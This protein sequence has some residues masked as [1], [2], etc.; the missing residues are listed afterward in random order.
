M[1]VT[2]PAGFRAGGVACGI[3]ESGAPDLADV[4]LAAADSYRTIDREALTAEHHAWLEREQAQR[5]API[6][7]QVL[8]GLLAHHVAD[9]RVLR[10]DNGGAGL[11]VDHF[12]GLSHFQR[13]VH[14]KRRP[15][16]QQIARSPA[17]LE[18]GQLS[19]DRV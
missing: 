6:Q 18:T 17:G 2:S 7:R 10:L 13:H 4:V 15:Y 14:R 16:H 9:G 11:H 3:K 8:D 12:G 19:R 1:S 5:I